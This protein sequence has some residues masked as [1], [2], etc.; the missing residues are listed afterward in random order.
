M[1]LSLSRGCQSSLGWGM[2]NLLAWS[3]EARPTR[4][5]K[6]RQDETGPGNRHAAAGIKPCKPGK[7]TTRCFRRSI[8]CWTL[9]MMMVMMPGTHCD[10]G[11]ALRLGSGILDLGVFGA[12]LGTVGNENNN[13]QI[14]RHVPGWH[15]ERDS[16]VTAQADDNFTGR[17]MQTPSLGRCLVSILPTCSRWYN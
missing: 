12:H 5:C 17:E 1:L 6:W 13:S 2:G 4:I 9:L 16:V 14:R 8:S 11:N 7:T 10:A 3:D 15:E